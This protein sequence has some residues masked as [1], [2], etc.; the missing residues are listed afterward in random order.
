MA[1][2][3]KM[4]TI[5]SLFTESSGLS[6]VC[7]RVPQRS[8]EFA[9]VNHSPFSALAVSSN[10]EVHRRLLHP[11]HRSLGLWS[12][13]TRQGRRPRRRQGS[14]PARQAGQGPHGP[15]HRHR[16]SE[17]CM[18]QVNNGGLG[19]HRGSMCVCQ[20]YRS[21]IAASAVMPENNIG[22]LYADLIHCVWSCNNIYLL[23]NACRGPQLQFL[24]FVPRRNADLL[25]RKIPTVLWAMGST[26]CCQYPP[27]MRLDATE[28]FGC[29]CRRVLGH[30]LFKDTLCGVDLTQT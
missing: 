19:R 12:P 16:R 4:K 15:A 23:N 1:H 8:R 26:K 10:H 6:F 18:C 25:H 22:L 14:L 7:I 13:D 30:I 20:A 3:R 17:F 28:L 5:F 29:G 27:N 2:A 11:G 21:G 24:A 9:A